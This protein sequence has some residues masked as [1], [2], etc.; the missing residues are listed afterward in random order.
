M[1]GLGGCSA[2]LVTSFTSAPHVVGG[3]VEESILHS[4]LAKADPQPEELDHLHF[5]SKEATLVFTSNRFTI[6]VLLA[7]SKPKLV[8]EGSVGCH[9]EAAVLGK[10]GDAL[11]HVSAHVSTG[12]CGNCMCRK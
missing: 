8:V 12:C 4:A 5:G 3:L 1:R 9:P 2:L 6:W 7:D 11:R 10:G